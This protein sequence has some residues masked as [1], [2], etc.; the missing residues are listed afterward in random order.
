VTS[1]FLLVLLHELFINAGVQIALIFNQ[2]IKSQLNSTH[3]A[4]WQITFTHFQCYR[5]TQPATQ[6]PWRGIVSW[7]V[8]DVLEGAWKEAVCQ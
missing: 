5:M 2:F 7:C 6:T 4:V 1:V 3:S 8:S